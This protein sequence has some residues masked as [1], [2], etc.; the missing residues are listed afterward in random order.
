MVCSI[1]FLFK[2]KTAY[3]LLISDWSSDVC[4]SYLGIRAPVRVAAGLAAGTARGGTRVAIHGRVDPR[5]VRGERP[6]RRSP[7]SLHSSRRVATGG[8]G[9]MRSEERR[10][11]TECVSTSRSRWSPYT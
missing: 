2:Q 7:W 6:E 5:S 9:R 4:S 11:G 8:Y 10:V 3:D 1:F